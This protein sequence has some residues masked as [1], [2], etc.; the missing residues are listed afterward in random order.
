MKNK[1]SRI[2]CSR[3]ALSLIG[4]IVFLF[5]G[6]LSASATTL[7]VNGFGANGWY[8][9]DTR[10][11]S[12]TQLVGTNNTSPA[13]PG[14]HTAADDAIIQ[15]Q[16]NFM[17]EG[18]TLNDAAGGTPP[19]SPTGS[20][21]GLGYVRL[22]GTSSNSGK[23]DLSYINT[24]G[25]ASATSLTNASFSLIYRYY[26]QPNPTFR[27][28]GL[29]I[30]LTNAAQSNLYTFAYVQPGAVAGWDTASVSA[31]S[32]LFTLF[33]NGSSAEGGAAKTLADW[34]TD[35]TFGTAI[36]GGSE[37]I[38]RVGFNIGS[39][40]KSGLEYLDW[41]QTN[42]LNGGDVID[43]QAV[44]DSGTTVALLGLGLMGIAGFSL[45]N[46]SAKV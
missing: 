37:E 5:S 23:S 34:A 24:N 4:G 40:Q 18:Q 22:D 21:N 9:W 19:A 10:N 14:T 42:L 45:R 1:F 28:L 27:T 32:G 20:L 35:A 17:G 30:S 41:M 25:I 7:V 15:Q 2:Y 26:I 11:T 12:G 39:G 33:A 8:S 3:L 44:S 38:F 46:R 31:S 16:I 13:W 43:F 36:F 29:N 6:I